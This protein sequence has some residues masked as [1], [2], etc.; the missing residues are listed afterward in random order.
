MRLF[1][2]KE[3]KK[4]TV[5]FVQLWD[6]ILSANLRKNN[7]SFGL[8]RQAP[9]YVDLVGMYS[10]EDNVTYMY[11]I[12][13]YPSELEVSY[14]STLR[15]ECKNGVRLSFISTFEK[16]QIPWTSPNMKAKLKKIVPE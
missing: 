8:L 12:D 15:K 10:G 2:G 16:Y 11:S 9:F 14:R 6:E 4:R 5:N 1:R 13:G 7:S 3:H